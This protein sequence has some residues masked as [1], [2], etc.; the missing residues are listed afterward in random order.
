MDVLPAPRFSDIR[1]SLA[2]GGGALMDAGCYAVHCL[3]TL[4]QEEPSVVAAAALLKSPGVDRAMAADLRFPSGAT[5]RV[6]ASMWSGDLLKVVAQV[7]GER[8]TLR[9]TNYAAPQFFHRV[10]V[11]V[12]GVRRRERV[13]GG[14]TYDYQL[15]A[16]ATA[17]RGGPPPLTPPADSIANMTVIDAIY[18]KAGLSPRGL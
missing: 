18:R 14:P 10:T 9:I 12:D 7:Q 11:T 15:R 5:G 16:F 1:Y 8:G 17:V 6:H 13:P 4:G 2:L 3:R